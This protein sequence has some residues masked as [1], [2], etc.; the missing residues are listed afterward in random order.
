M[1]DSGVYVSA[2]LAGLGQIQLQFLAQDA[3]A[4]LLYLSAHASAFVAD[5]TSRRLSAVQPALMQACR[6]ITVAIVVLEESN[7]SPHHRRQRRGTQ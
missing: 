1:E 3:V 2:R 7:E 4:L 5:H 6:P